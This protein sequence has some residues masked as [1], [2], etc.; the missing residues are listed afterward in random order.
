MGDYQMNVGGNLEQTHFFGKSLHLWPKNKHFLPSKYAK[1]ANY[2]HGRPPKWLL[3]AFRATPFCVQ[4]LA[5]LTPKLKDFCI[6]CKWGMI[7]QN[8][9]DVS[10]SPPC[11]S[12]KSTLFTQVVSAEFSFWHEYQS[13]VILPTSRHMLR[14]ELISFVN[15]KVVL[16]P[17]VYSEFLSDI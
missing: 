4:I 9:W 11:P 1:C 3:R 12:A 14:F 6:H 7:L 16:N 17:K 8:Q 10:I 5:F 2:C 13:P 15:V